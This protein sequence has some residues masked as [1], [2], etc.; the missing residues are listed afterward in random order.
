MS[1]ISIRSMFSQYLG[2]Q[3]IKW[4]LSGRCSL[5]TVYLSYGFCNRHCHIYFVGIRSYLLIWKRVSTKQVEFSLSRL[6]YLANSNWLWF[7]KNCDVWGCLHSIYSSAAKY[8]VWYHFRPSPLYL[9]EKRPLFDIFV[10]NNKHFKLE[11]Y[12]SVLLM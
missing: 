11:L 8:V 2:Y 3:K 1:D 12:E 4:H 5:I 6:K 7:L 10:L 9:S